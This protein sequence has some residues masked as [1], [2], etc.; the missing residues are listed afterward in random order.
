MRRTAVIAVTVLA[1]ALVFGGIFVVFTTPTIQTAPEPG[2]DE[3]Q[4]FSFEGDDSGVWPYL[5]PSES[6]RQRSPINVLVRADA[7]TVVTALQSSGNFTWNETD[8][9]EEHADPEDSIPRQ[10]NLSNT[11]IDWGETTGTARYAYIY[12]GSGD[13][14]TDGEWIGETDQLHNGDYYGHRTHIRLYES[15]VHEEEPWVAMQVHTEHF[16]W[17]TLRHAVDGVEEGQRQVEQ[18]FMSLDNVD[19]VWRT[20]LAN[21]GPSD[22][23]GW[24]TVV[25]LTITL[26][27]L[28]VGMLS[29]RDIW[30]R[31]LT[32]VDRARARA[33]RNR[34]SIQQTFLVTSIVAIVLGVRAGGI[35]LEWHTGLSMHAIAGLLY[36]FIAVGIPIVTYVFSQQ[37][38]RRMDAAVTASAALGIG[39]LLDYGYLGVEVLPIE[40]VIQ[41]TG[42]IMAL[43]L[44]AAGAAKRATRERRLNKLL[45]S[46][47]LL[48]IGLLAATLLEYI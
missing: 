19:L 3:R 11:A 5:S 30:K 36:P 14:W 35:L 8:R 7:D 24:A 15:P 4:L 40:V 45:V 22:A 41:R 29:M 32:S 18:E 42:V 34:L 48:W 1:L 20:Y 37:L 13:P 47:V 39:F 26:P 21:D 33:I 2:T 44:I 9:V 25:E 17:F 46:G 43:G 27:G 10:L 6:F 12:D 16:D 31:R 28:L 38:T 23:D